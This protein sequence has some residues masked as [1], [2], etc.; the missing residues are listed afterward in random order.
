MASNDKRD[1][2]FDV[3]IVGGG[4][5]GLHAASIL[6]DSGFSVALFEKNIEI[7]R[8]VVCSGVISREAF[9]RY[10]LPEEAIVGKLQ[11]AD[12][13]SP[14]GVCINYSHPEEAVVVVDRHIFD[15]KLAE[16]AV[17][18]GAEIFLDTEISSI[19]VNDDHVKAFIKTK[20]GKNEVNAAICV[21]ATGINYHLQSSLGLGRPKKILKGIQIETKLEHIKHLRMYWGSRFST[22]F[23]GWAF[24]LIDGRTRI[25][26]ITEGDALSGINNIMSDIGLYQ[27]ACSEQIKPKRRGIAFGAITRSYS[28][29]IIAVG[30]AAGFIK[31]TTG[32]GI[33]YGLLSAEMASEVIKEAFHTGKF[34]AKALSRYEK[35]WKG[36]L[37]KEIKYGEYF[38]KLFSKLDDN[39]I[40]LLFDAAI[41]DNLLTYITNNGKFDWHRDTIAKIIRSPNLRR[42]LWNRLRGGRIEDL[43]CG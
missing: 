14:K 21:I 7:G 1:R 18:Q 11:K 32:G 17:S 5:S 12:L 19:S 9:S 10:D 8:D 22:S 24:P 35:L 23:F 15:K 39:S 4:P 30:E 33:Y 26:V 40:E 25:G 6:A 37:G 16:K 13:L 41:K 38:N 3:V 36:T 29:R 31:T 34:H 42:V 43:S 28:D 2:Y 27:D 20:E